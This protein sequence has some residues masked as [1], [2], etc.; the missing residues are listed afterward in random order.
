M[1]DAAF[2][3]IQ[4]SE[5]ERNFAP[6]TR[7]GKTTLNSNVFIPTPSKANIWVSSGM[8]GTYQHLPNSTFI[9]LAQ[10]NIR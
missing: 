1:H 2:Q 3:A 9:S 5:A 6:K 8:K 4:A 7:I 10:F